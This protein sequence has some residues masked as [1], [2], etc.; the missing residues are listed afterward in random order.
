MI[1]AAGRKWT[2]QLLPLNHSNTR[3][4]SADTIAFIFLANGF[5]IKIFPL[6]WGVFQGAFDRRRQLCEFQQKSTWSFIGCAVEM[7][8]AIVLPLSL[9]L[10]VAQSTFIWN[11]FANTHNYLLCAS[12]F[13]T[14]LLNRF[15][16]TFFAHSSFHVHS[17]WHPEWNTTWMRM[18]NGFFFLHSRPCVVWNSQKH[19]DR[20][21]S[22][23]IMI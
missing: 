18:S 20:I 11:P 17:I 12:L 22:N 8:L 21:Y 1:I 7:L 16:S 4:T 6:L 13:A 10:S 9:S 23:P 14:L 15:S 3:I 5:H 19:P 2:Q